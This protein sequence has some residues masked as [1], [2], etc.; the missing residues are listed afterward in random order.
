LLEV[1]WRDG[2]AWYR[3]LG[4]VRENAAAR[5]TLR[6]ETSLISGQHAD[7]VLR[8]ADAATERPWMFSGF[9]SIRWTGSSKSTLT[10]AQRFTGL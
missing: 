2:V 3:L 5:L 4:D 1:A 8:M 6:G 9:G 7:F 10:S